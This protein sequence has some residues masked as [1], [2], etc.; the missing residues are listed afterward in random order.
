MNRGGRSKQAGEETPVLEQRDTVVMA[1]E[2]LK[3]HPEAC[4]LDRPTVGR[5]SYG[6]VRKGCEVGQH[7]SMTCVSAFLGEKNWSRSKVGRLLEIADK[8]HESLAKSIA[9]PTGSRK[10]G[11]AAMEECYQ[12]YQTT[13]FLCPP[14]A[15]IDFCLAPVGPLSLLLAIKTRDFAGFLKRFF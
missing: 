12:C 7:G 3:K 2:Y 10:G 1:R 5:S 15:P 11:H 6:G 9:P 13:P 14:L 4:K 8:L